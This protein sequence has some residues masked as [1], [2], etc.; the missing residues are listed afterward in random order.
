MLEN[1]RIRGCVLYLLAGLILG[2]VSTIC[3][4]LAYHK[5]IEYALKLLALDAV[6]IV[7]LPI[8][9]FVTNP[10]FQRLDGLEDRF[11]RAIRNSKSVK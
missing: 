10:L 6:V 11:W 2:F 3:I 5:S 9:F 4:T 8:I 1:R 7:S